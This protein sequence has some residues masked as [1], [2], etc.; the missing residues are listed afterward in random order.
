MGRD[1]RGNQGASLPASQVLLG[2]SDSSIPGLVVGRR[3]VE[4]GFPE[5]T[6]HPGPRCLVG[7]R[8]LKVMHVN[9]RCSAA[10]NH[11]ETTEPGTPANELLVD[12]SGFSRENVFLKPGE[13]P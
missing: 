12:I 1:C 8:V 4:H 5:H 9:E 7:D 3:E 11:L 6:P 2:V 10:E 13:Q